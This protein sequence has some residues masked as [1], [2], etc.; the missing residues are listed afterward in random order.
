MRRSWLGR[1]L[2]GLLGGWLA[3][4]GLAGCPEPVGDDD[5]STVEGDDDGGETLGGEIHGPETVDFGEVRQAQPVTE[6]VELRNRGLEP[7]E[8][9][10]VQVAGDPEGA[11]AV[12]YDAPLPT[13]L[14]P[15]LMETVYLRLEVTYDPVGAGERLAQLEIYSSDSHYQPDEPHVIPLFGLGLVDQDGDG[16]WWAPG[17][18]SSQADCDDGDPTVGPSQDE[19]CDGLDNDCDGAL[20][21]DE[22][23]ADGDGWMACD[24]PLGGDCDDLDPDRYPGNA[25]LCDAVDNDCDGVVPADEADADADGFRICA[26]DCDDADDAV[27]PGAPELCNRQDDDCDGALPADEQD[28]DGDG[29][30]PCEGD[31]DDVDA[32]QNLADA[33]G[34]GHTT[35]AG[36][37]DDADDAV[38]PGAPEQCNRLDD[39]CDGLLPPDEIDGDS[40]GATACEGDCDDADVAFNLLD[41]DGD[42]HTSCAGDCDDNDDEIHPAATEICNDGIDQDCDGGPGACSHTGVIE[43][44]VDAEAHFAPQ[45]GGAPNGVGSGVDL[46][47]VDG[48]GL[49]DVI[50]GIPYADSFTVGDGAVVLFLGPVSGDL[51]FEDADAVY[52]GNGQFNSLGRAVAHTGDVDGDGFGD[53]LF[54]AKND[55][56]IG[57][58]FLV[59]GYLGGELEAESNAARLEGSETYSRSADTIAFAGDFNGDGFDDFIIGESAE[60]SVSQGAGAAFM[61]LGS[62]TRLPSTGLFTDA[63]LAFVGETPGDYA[64]CSVSGGGDIDSDG[65][66]DIVIGAEYESS[67]AVDGGAAYVLRGS[68]SLQG[69]TLDLSLSEAKITGGTEFAGHGLE[70][71]VA[72]DIDG[73]GRDEVLIAFPYDSTNGPSCGAV[74]L[75][76][77]PLAGDLT[78]TDAD[79]SIH[80]AVAAIKAGK[81]A[82]G[83]GDIDG[84]G[85]GDLAIGAPFDATGGVNSGTVFLFYGPGVSWSSTDDADAAIVGPTHFTAGYGLGTGGDANGDG[86][87]DLLVGAPQWGG[88]TYG[89][90]F[91]Y[92]LLGAGM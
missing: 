70:V 72:S 61:F 36:D 75:F 39:D 40:D 69:P 20:P 87:D 79:A 26:G 88:L 12:E 10:L 7:L 33:D 32:A 58:A 41:V 71:A 27:F 2:V 21:A 65:Y 4:G 30:T 53:I 92:L 74:H 56:D 78:T 38:F 16:D 73:D 35:C 51:D 47:D 11:F 18:D 62:A 46:G 89:T 28:L 63:D 5:D 81:A 8:I 45:G 55:S 50:F 13:T 90:G 67:G 57:Q 60:A 15:D 42:G 54:N 14:P 37:C 83:V 24:G 64:A 44:P 52:M 68:N 43:L 48:D 66:D 85:Y 25:E 17:W 1:G 9:T 29:T 86:Y 19:I 59:Y 76:L 84:D 82:Q 77:G 49:D 31:C 80:G 3:V 91:I 6:P 34:D 22:A 23:D